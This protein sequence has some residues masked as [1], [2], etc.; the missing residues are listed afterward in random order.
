MINKEWLKELERYTFLDKAERKGLKY[1]FFYTV[2]GE[3]KF[4]ILPLRA[5]GPMVQELM[6]KIKKEVGVNYYGTAKTRIY[7]T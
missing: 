1:Y 4:K 2:R 3:Q 5:T 6:N 7:G